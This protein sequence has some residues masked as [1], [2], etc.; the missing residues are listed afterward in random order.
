M[1]AKEALVR[2]VNGGMSVTAAAV[3][4]GVARSCAYKWVARYR[5]DGLAGLEERSRVPEYSPNRTPQNVVNDLLALKKKHPDFGPAKLASMLETKHGSHVLAVSTA[6]E[7]LAR[8][9]LVK[10]RPSRHRSAGRIEHLPFTIAGAGDSMTADYK[11]QFLLKNG[12]LCYPLTIADPFSRYVFAIDAL[13]STNIEGARAGFERVFRKY[14]VPR[15]MISDNGGPFCC[16]VALGGLTQLSR[17]W[18]ELGIVPIRIQPGHPQQNGI[19]ERMHRTLKD[20]IRRNVRE[21]FRKM[22]R[23]FNAFRREFNEVRPHQSLGQKPPATAVQPYR[24]YIAR[25]RKIEYDMNMT[26]RSVRSNGQIKWN[27]KML[28]MSEVLSGANVGLL[29]VD[30]ALWAIYF[31]AVRIGYLDAQANRAQNRLPDRLTR[32]LIVQRPAKLQ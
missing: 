18:I 28:F 8:H 13:P 21:N 5:S 31:G 15:Q 30:E 20:W 27:G 16:S 11:G 26:V 23:S 3:L 1:S 22:Q 32:N 10:K 25:P 7:L 9:A 6:G 24:P 2:D 14:G 29:E 4:H 12:A 19:H 17:W